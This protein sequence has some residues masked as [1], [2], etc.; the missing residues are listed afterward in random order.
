[1]DGITDLAAVIGL[2]SHLRTAK[3]VLV[4]N[5]HK[6]YGQINN[7]GTTLARGP[8]MWVNGGREL[9]RRA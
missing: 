2:H 9:E 5:A 6:T 3:S 7:F 8:A 4:D 1:M